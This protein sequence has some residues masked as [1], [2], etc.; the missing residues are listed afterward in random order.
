[1]REVTPRSA[2][3]AI[4]AN[5]EEYLSDPENSPFDLLKVSTISGE[6]EA[7][8]AF[9]SINSGIS[10]KNDWYGLLELGGASTQYAVYYDGVLANSQYLLWEDEVV[11]F[12]GQSLPDYG[13]DGARNRYQESLVEDTN[14]NSDGTYSAVCFSTNY[15]EPYTTRNGTVVMINGTGDPVAC[16]S[17]INNLLHLDYYCPLPPCGPLGR[18]VPELF[19]DKEYVA[20]SAFYFTANGLGLVDG[21]NIKLTHSEYLQAASDN[22]NSMIPEDGDKFA[23]SLCF[24]SMYGGLLLKSYGF[25]ED[26]S[27]TFAKKMNNRS[28]DWTFAFMGIQRR[29]AYLRCPSTTNVYAPSS[30]TSTDEDVDE[31]VDEEA[32]EE[33]DA[34]EDGDEDGDAD[35]DGDGDAD[36]D[37]GADAG[38][39]EGEGEDE[40]AASSSSSLKVMGTSASMDTDTDAASSSSLKAMG[41]SI[42]LMLVVI[43]TT[44][45][46]FLIT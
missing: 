10:D 41:T 37:A 33:A 26:Q 13:L 39:G 28:V 16:T 38:E 12:Y 43:I 42:A 32:D 14:P 11:D 29:E 25:D 44:S 20:V 27:I 36:E 5:T 31:E 1:M 6:Q 34:D 24:D 19:P 40:D 21:D 2:Q 15:L 4:I 3:L 22:C 18:Y 46:F 7:S 30:S 35:G 17:V 45:P 23:K 9:I 8:A